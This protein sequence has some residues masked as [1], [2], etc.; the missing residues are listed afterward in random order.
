MVHRARL[1]F[2]ASGSGGPGS[3]ELSFQDEAEEGVPRY[4]TFRDQ[5]GE[6]RDLKPGSLRERFD[7]QQIRH[8]DGEVRQDL[9]SSLPQQDASEFD[10]G[11]RRLQ[12]VAGRAPGSRSP[13]E[14]PCGLFEVGLLP[15]P[16]GP[17]EHL[18]RRPA[19]LLAV[20]LGGG[21]HRLRLPPGGEGGVHSQERRARFPPLEQTFLRYFPLLPLLQLLGHFCSKPAFYGREIPPSKALSFLGCHDRSVLDTFA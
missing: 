16:L 4:G 6:D 1:L 15:S 20:G 5:G 3:V 18:R 19:K 7:F 14:E 2:G 11:V 21:H 13:P 8:P 12:H 10:V 9:P 17:G